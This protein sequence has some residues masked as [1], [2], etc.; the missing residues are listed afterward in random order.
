MKK[1]FLV[2]A[3]LSPGGAERFFANLARELS[4]YARV[5]VVTLT[6]RK[7]TIPLDPSI[8]LIR[9][10]ASRSIKAL[11]PLYKI[12]RNHR[13]DI[14]VSTLIQT[15]FVVSLLIPFF[16]KTRFFAR[17]TAIASKD[18]FTEREYIT[19]RLVS[20]FFYPF[21]YKIIFQSKF[22]QEDHLKTFNSHLSNT[23]INNFVN[24]PDCKDGV[25]LPKENNLKVFTICR[26]DKVKQIEHMLE[27]VAIAAKK[28]NISFAVIGDGPQLDELKELSHK[29]DIENIVS[30]L[31][32]QPNPT[33]VIKDMD[34][35]LMASKCGGFPNALLESLAVGKPVISYDSPGGTGEIVTSEKYGVL[36]PLNSIS[37]LADAITHFSLDR[38]DKTSIR[39]E[40][41]KRFSKEAIV[42]KYRD[43]LN[44]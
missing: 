40:T 16:P 31:G 21:F 30:F 36:V 7:T 25:N 42:K 35:L 12:L 15:N 6:K 20:K 29:L 34:V 33:E 22:M 28:R 4:P 41:L 13:P 17:E 24:R 1:I 38:Y 2:I 8:E 14:V 43:L 32:Y 39:E 18:Y 27:A 19:A 5:S 9:I 10:D 11:Y 3:S 44:L 23:V 37:S 26:L